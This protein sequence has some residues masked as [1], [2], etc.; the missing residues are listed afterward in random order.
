MNVL[1]ISAGRLPASYFEKARWELGNGDIVID[2]LAWLPPEEPVDKLLRHYLLLGPGQM[3]LPASAQT[4]I[5]TRESEWPGNSPAASA[6]EG[7]AG[8]LGA[9]SLRRW[10]RTRI[11]AGLLRRLNRAKRS[12]AARKVRRLVFGGPSRQLWSRVR[13]HAQAQHL[14]RNADLFVVVDTGG[15][16]TG[17]HI[18]RRHPATGAVFGL[19]AAA[20]YVKTH[21]RSQTV[22]IEHRSVGG[23]TAR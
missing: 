5:S 7:G 6:A 4:E 23:L 11:K 18:A 16:R 17:W 1:L 9:D 15:L 20:Q 12:R 21:R 10:N 2:V 13:G 19:P 14:A 22:G 3:P 8:Q